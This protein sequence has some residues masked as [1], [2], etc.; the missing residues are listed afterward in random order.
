MENEKN[1]V[2]DGA[3][4]QATEQAPRGK[5][6]STGALIG[7]IAGGVALV[8]AIVVLL[9]IFAGGCKEHVDMDDDFLCD[10]CGKDY[11]D[12]LE[13]I[14]ETVRFTVMLEGEALS[15]VKFTLVNADDDKRYDFTT[16]AQGKAS[17]LLPV[18]EYTVEYDYTTIAESISSD[19]YL[20][21]V[22]Q[23]MDE[24]VITLADNTPDGSAE[25]PFYI[26]EN[27]TE[28]TIEPAGELHFNY[29]GAV[30]KYLTINSDKLVVIYEETEYTA[31]DGVIEVAITSKEIGTN[32]S[33]VV[34]NISGETVNEIMTLLAPLGSMD[35]P[36]NL[37]EDYD[38]KIVPAEGTI[39][40]KWTAVED[41]VI[42][43]YVPDNKVNSV[44]I[45]KVLE[46]DVPVSSFSSGDSYAYMPVSAGDTVTIAI[47]TSNK[48]DTL[49]EFEGYSYYGNESE[50]VPAFVK[51]IDIPLTSGQSLSVST[52]VGNTVTIADEE[53]ISVVY[54]GTT[55]T[56]DENGKISFTIESGCDFFTVT[57]TSEYVNSVLIKV[58][59]DLK[60]KPN[61]GV[62][63]DQS[64]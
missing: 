43:I 31:V 23:G 38:C 8:V 4:A 54:N 44:G 5:K 36:Y 10:N 12:G 35:N 53:N 59:G 27:E 16:D 56:P 39:Y 20:V 63:T 18:G 26:S 37:N 34:K 24:I 50:P 9:I 33:F 48:E 47:S 62:S 3:E 42:V 30:T 2:A 40:Y 11:N 51:D 1:I 58:D 21:V 41:Y 29:R 46:N 15:G 22:E 17:S 52:K 61:Y 28:I 6:L 25:K 19:T 57:N 45:T 13:I 49:V 55:Y 60:D 32:A 7:I 14:T 64:K